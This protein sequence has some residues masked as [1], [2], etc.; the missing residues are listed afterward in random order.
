[1]NRRHSYSAADYLEDQRHQE[2][3]DSR[4]ERLRERR[5]ADDM[6][7]RKPSTVKPSTV[8]PVAFYGTTA[9]EKV[10]SRFDDD[11]QNFSDKDGN[12]LLEV[13]DG[14]AECAYHNGS[15]IYTFHD[16]SIIGINENYWDILEFLDGPR[17]FG[18]YGTGG[19]L[20]V[21]TTANGEIK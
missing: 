5:F 19:D 20:Y 13:L 1:M 14:L 6:A 16:S 15:A 2:D 17:G 18:L 9:A 12:Y 11:G 7:E 3:E 4:Q 21:R 10:S 8:K